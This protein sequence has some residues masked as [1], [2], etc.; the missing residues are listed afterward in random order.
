MV[1]TVKAAI[2]K[3]YARFANHYNGRAVYTQKRGNNELTA[4]YIEDMIAF[5]KKLYTEATIAHEAI[6]GHYT[7]GDEY[8]KKWMEY[9]NDYLQA[10]KSYEENPTIMKQNGGEEPPR[11]PSKK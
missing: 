2:E 10:I 7:M 9:E 6:E 11:V 3:Q 1:D 4:K 5:I 8:Q